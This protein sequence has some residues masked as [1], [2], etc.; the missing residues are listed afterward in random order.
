MKNKTVAKSFLL[1]TFQ[2]TE[3]LKC[4][5]ICT[6]ESDMTSVICSCY[7]GYEMI[8]DT[9]VDVDECQ[10]NNG[11]CFAICFNT[12]GSYQCSCPSGFTTGPDGKSCI[13][14]NECLLRNGHGPCQDKCTNV[15]GSY[16]C[17]CERIGG[18]RLAEDKVRNLVSLG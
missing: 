5:Q 17:S 10:V 6:E 11:G 12:P 1:G 2:E 8:N 9:C 7:S 3:C 15:P 4:E 18:T 14:K 13:D 16:V